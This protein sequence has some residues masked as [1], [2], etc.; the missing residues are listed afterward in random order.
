MRR[1][2]TLLGVALLALSAACT[3]APQVR[4]D[5]RSGA[6]KGAQVEGVPFIPQRDDTCGA[7]ALG[8]VLQ[9]MGVDASE[10]TLAKALRT[11]QEH[12]AITYELVIEARNQ[13]A[14]AAQRCDTTTD[15]LMRAIDAGMTPIVLRGSLA[16]ALL[17]VY[18]YTVLTAYDLN[19]R[20]WIAHDGDEAD[21]LIDF[22]TLAEDRMRADRWA[23]FVASPKARPKG[24]SPAIHLELGVQAEQA[25]HPEAAAHHYAQAAWTPSTAQALINLGNVALAEERFE[26]AERLL[27]A[28]LL[29]DPEAATVKNN[30][31]WVLLQRGHHL[32]EGEALAEQAAKTLEIR[33]QALDTLA[34]LRAARAA[35][36]AAPR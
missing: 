21:V 13:G 4:A 25:K 16:H 9:H 10:P 1:L 22:E 28:A 24:L 8:A 19:R 27:R 14:L 30:L 31:A 7:A 26:Q 32:D 3:S 15:Q 18:H 34:Q 23:L 5:L 2:A 17:G 20:V 29:I 35:Q 12:G 11:R 36:D 6:V 33:P